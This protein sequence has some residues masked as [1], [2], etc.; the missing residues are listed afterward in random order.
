M[1]R[2]NKSVWGP[3]DDG[4]IE[5]F[6]YGCPEVKCALNVSPPL[7]V[8]LSFCFFSSFFLLLGGVE[9][10]KSDPAVGFGEA[11]FGP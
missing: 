4:I 9:G 2:L 6:W 1:P 5:L 10:L 11:S 8:C 3:K 7:S